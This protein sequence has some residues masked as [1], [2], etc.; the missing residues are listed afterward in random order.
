MFISSIKCN[1]NPE[2]DIVI[3]S[4]NTPP[5]PPT[6][7]SPPSFPTK[8]FLFFSRNFHVPWLETLE[9]I[10]LSHYTEKLGAEKGQKVND[11]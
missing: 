3:F 7:N 9:K 6:S 5:S 1:K 11:I 4:D 8:A 2:S 10:T